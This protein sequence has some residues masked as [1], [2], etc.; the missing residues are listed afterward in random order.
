MRAKPCLEFVERL[1]AG[2]LIAKCF[3]CAFEC[4]SNDA[5]ET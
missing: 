5:P 1:R 2:F 3:L 4:V